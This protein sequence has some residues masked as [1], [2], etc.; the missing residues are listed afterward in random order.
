[1]VKAAP[2][3]S[4]EM[5]ETNFLLEILVVALDAP[6]QLGEVHQAFEGDVLGQG[7]EP[8]FGGISLVG[9]PLDQ[10]PFFGTAPNGAP[11]P[12]GGVAVCSTHADAGEAGRQPVGRSLAPSDILPGLGGQT[13]GEVFDLDR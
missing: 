10:Q 12:R 7:C 5:T 1:M 4:F 9:G 6:A 11:A 2:S 13:A 8:I 3:S